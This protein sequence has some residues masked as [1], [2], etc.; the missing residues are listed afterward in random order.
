MCPT[1]VVRPRSTLQASRLFKTR[2]LIHGFAFLKFL[3]PARDLGAV[4]VLSCALLR[5]MCPASWLRFLTGWIELCVHLSCSFVCSVL[6]TPATLS[7]SCPLH[8]IH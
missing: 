2:L 4:P 1:R 8:S 5:D 3:L 6:A 7:P